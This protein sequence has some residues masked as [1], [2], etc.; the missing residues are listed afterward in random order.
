MFGFITPDD[1]SKKDVFVHYT[2][3][4]KSG[5]K[6]L[7]EGQLVEFEI[8]ETEKG[9]KAADVVILDSVKTK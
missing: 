9:L 7:E 3:I 4:N 2:A 6:S 1:K 5:F 8:L